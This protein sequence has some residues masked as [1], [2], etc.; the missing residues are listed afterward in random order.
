MTYCT[1]ALVNGLILN[2]IIDPA[3]VDLTTEAEQIAQLLWQGLRP[4]APTE[5]RP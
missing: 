5:R 2:Y 4:V 3:T 1:D